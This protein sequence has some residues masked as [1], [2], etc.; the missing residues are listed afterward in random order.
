[1]TRI[2]LTTAMIACLTLA[3]CINIQNENGPGDAAAQASTVGSPEI[4]PD[5]DLE[6]AAPE[7]AVITEDPNATDPNGGGE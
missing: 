5:V 1:M 2:P 6:Q 7:K 4:K 3:G